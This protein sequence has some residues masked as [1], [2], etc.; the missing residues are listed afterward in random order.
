MIRTIDLN[1]MPNPSARQQLA[2]RLIRAIEEAATTA[3]APP[4]H[5]LAASTFSKLQY[6]F[7]VSWLPN[8]DPSLRPP[9]LPWCA[10]AWALHPPLSHA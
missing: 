9:P 8:W 10:R 5:A 1:K 2:G 7:P 6:D 4:Q 3:P